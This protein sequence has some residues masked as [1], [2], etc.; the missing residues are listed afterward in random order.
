MNY[1]HIYHAGNF[2]DVMKHVIL[3]LLLQKLQE[4][5]KA[6]FVLDTHA[7]IGLY[8]L[9]DVAA[10]KT[11]E[12]EGGI[13]RLLA[14]EPLPGIFQPYCDIVKAMNTGGIL[15]QYPGSPLIIQ[16][17]LRNQD[18][19]ALSELHPQDYETLK[20]HFLKAKQV[21][22]RHE[23][24]YTALK[25][26][27]P[28]KEKRGLVLIDPPFEEKDEVD[29]LINGIKEAYRRFATGIYAIWFPIKHR[30]PIDSFYE[31]LRYLGIPKIL[32]VEFLI[33]PATTPER[34]NGCGMVF[35]NPP[36]KLDTVL[37]ETLPLLLQLL[38]KQETGSVHVSWLVGEG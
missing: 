4:K 18:R 30:P 9:M 36:W 29:R 5:D 16:Q 22:V 27:L 14:V 12:Y 25:A 1:R 11:R 34:L 13:A 3:T 15:V 32:A 7:G 35:I 28:P 33:A 31:T 19:M 17:F 6:F 23:D 21:E 26:F 24:A 10:Q 8:N 20:Q 38:G 2:A 37:E